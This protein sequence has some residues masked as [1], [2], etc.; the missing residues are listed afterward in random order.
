VIR[1][2]ARKYI[3]MANRF[4]L[5]V[6]KLGRQVEL[7][8]EDRFLFLSRMLGVAAEAVRIVRSSRIYSRTLQRIGFMGI[9]LM[10]I[11]ATQRIVKLAIMSCGVGVCRIHFQIMFQE[12]NSSL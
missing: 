1:G 8:L 10:A 3:I 2:S 4:F 5:Q 7:I 12:Q 6:S 9:V 11:W